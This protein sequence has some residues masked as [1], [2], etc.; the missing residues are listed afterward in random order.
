MQ[1]KSPKYS[2]DTNKLVRMTEI[3]CSFIKR[4][5]NIRIKDDTYRKM[6]IRQLERII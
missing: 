6:L 4:A 1:K 5:S 2:V 3:I